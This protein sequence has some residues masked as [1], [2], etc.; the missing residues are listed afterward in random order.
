MAGKKVD[1]TLNRSCNLK[2][3]KSIN[4]RRTPLKNNRYMSAPDIKGYED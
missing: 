4:N 2:E 1:E 3:R